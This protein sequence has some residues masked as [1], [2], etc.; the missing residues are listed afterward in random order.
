[1][2]RGQGG[3]GRTTAQEDGRASWPGALQR[4]D[5]P[6]G[7]GRGRAAGPRPLQGQAPGLPC[8]PPLPPAYGQAVCPASPWHLQ[9]L[10]SRPV[11][12]AFLP[13]PPPPWS[14]A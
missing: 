5:G 8:A 1:M 2:I 10:G 9:R 4:Q 14:L 13:P 11:W 3:E 7:H 6:T 12:L